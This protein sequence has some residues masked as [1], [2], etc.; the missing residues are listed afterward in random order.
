ME[1]LTL[2]DGYDRTKKPA[3]AEYVRMSAEQA[4]RLQAGMPVLFLGVGG[5][6][7]RAKVNGSPKT[8]KRD[9]TRVEV[10]LKYGIRD[11]F[12]ASAQPDGTMSWLLIPADHVPSFDDCA[13]FQAAVNGN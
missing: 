10:P 8:W 2:V 3:T 12:T 4:R 11:Y 13:R 6:V 7:F 5:K 9:P 1:T